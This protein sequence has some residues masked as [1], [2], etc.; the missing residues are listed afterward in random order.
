MRN[1]QTAGRAK[2]RDQRVRLAAWS[3]MLL[4]SEGPEV[5]F[6]QFGAEAPPWLPLAQAGSLVIGALV[7]AR[8]PRFK[9]LDGFLL[10]LAG[11]RLG[12][13]VITPAIES[14]Q[15]FHNW[16]QH[17]DWGAR[18]FVGRAL[19]L[20]G[21]ILI[22]LTLLGSGI[23][24][25]DLFLCRG[26]LNAPAQ[27]E[28][29]LWFRR[30]ISWTHF[31]AALLVIFGVALPLFLFF[32]LPPDFARAGR[33]W[34]FLPW[35][36]AT[37]A[38]NAANEEFQFRSALLARLRSFLSDKEALLLTAALFGLGHYDGQ[39]SGPIG[40][41]M[42]GFAGWVWGKSMIETRGFTWAFCIHMVQDVVIFCFLVM[43]ANA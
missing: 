20:S 3:A 22:G 5:I 30:P 7:C 14:N 26:D 21:A 38:L 6:Q 32:S 10:A 27:P 43:A 39:P 13:S 42:A 33:I 37:A 15:A 36:I 28:P 34:R 2:N 4:A 9:K 35:G 23:T 25:R 11:L 16:T 29:M 31:G 24:R 19:P 40:V 12:W 41:V 8:S 17:L 1:V 18:L